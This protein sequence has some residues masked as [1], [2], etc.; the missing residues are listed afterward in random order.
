MSFLTKFSPLKDALGSIAGRGAVL[1]IAGIATVLSSRIVFEETGSFGFAWFSLL[2]S[3]PLLIPISDFGIGAV[4]TDE[5]AKH[6]LGSSA[7]RAVA[8]RAITL[9]CLI[10]GVAIGLGCA[11]TVGGFWAPVLGLPRGFETEAACLALGNSVL[12]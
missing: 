3:L 2:I 10:G 5:V 9:L 1:P 11:L 8:R 6:G 4:L 7:F 12:F